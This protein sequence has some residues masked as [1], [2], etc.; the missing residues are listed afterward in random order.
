MT[1]DFLIGENRHT[2]KMISVGKCIPDLR[3]AKNPNELKDMAIDDVRVKILEEYG[4]TQPIVVQKLDNGE[5]QILEGNRRWRAWQL[6]G[7]KKI[8]AFVFEKGVNDG[9]QKKFISSY[10]GMQRKP[11]T[12]EDKIRC[13]EMMFSG[14]GSEDQVA[15]SLG[16]S[17]AVVKRAVLYSRLSSKTKKFLEEQGYSLREVVRK[18]INT[19]LNGDWSNE[20]LVIK[21]LESL[22]HRFTNIRGKYCP[23][24]K[25]KKT[26]KIIW[27]LPS[28]PLT[29]DEVEKYVHGG[30]VINGIEH[31]YQCSECHFRWG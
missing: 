30:D 18:D 5:Y 21:L 15:K 3:N 24:C 14:Y 23:K 11:M 28:G 29:N 8:M 27:G 7:E 6:L 19:K 31:R 13:I 2:P 25:N 4:M 17:K 16:I 1:N 12:N 10:V 22:C 9:E 20:E 26:K